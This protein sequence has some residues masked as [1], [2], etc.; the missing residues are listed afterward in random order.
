MNHCQKEEFQSM[1]NHCVL[2][3]HY[4]SWHS[5][6]V[7]TLPQRRGWRCN[8]VVA[9][10][11]MRVVATSVSD[12]V[13]TMLSDAATTLLQR[14][15]NIKHMVSRP[16]YYGQFWFFSRHWIVRDLQNYVSIEFSFWQSRCTLVDSWLCLLLLCEQDKLTRLGAKVVMK[17][18]ETS[19]VVVEDRG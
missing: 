13:T 14:R 16:F 3:T 10:S 18:I 4:I 7:T 17:R 2:S 12:F 1:L 9:W 6:F 8:N 5:N 15:H 19:S 11:K